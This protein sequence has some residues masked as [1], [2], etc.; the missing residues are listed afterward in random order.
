LICSSTFC[1]SACHAPGQ[2]RPRQ[3]DAPV[4]LRAADADI[5]ELRVQQYLAVALLQRLHGSLRVARP[6]QAD[7]LCVDQRVGREAQRL[8][9]IPDDP[10][11]QEQ[12]RILRQRRQFPGRLA[13]TA[14][15]LRPVDV[16]RLHQPRLLVGPGSGGEQQSQ[17]QSGKPHHE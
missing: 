13:G 11:R 9:Q 8:P 3:H 17:R 10:G 14:L 6:G 2:E 7:R 16:D 12:P 1:P 15:H 5:D 4:A